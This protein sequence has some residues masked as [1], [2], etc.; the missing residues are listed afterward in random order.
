MSCAGTGWPE[1]MME[2]A[3]CQPE[4]SFRGGVL[5]T[6]KADPSFE[7]RYQPTVGSTIAAELPWLVEL[8]RGAFRDLIAALKGDPSITAGANLKRYINMNLTRGLRNS[9]GELRGYELHEDDCKVS[10]VV[11]ACSAQQKD[12]GERVSSTN[13]V[14]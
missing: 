1:A 7:T 3:K 5:K 6:S 10:I 14:S 13:K 8:Y 2:V 4:V 11:A 12:W 9:N